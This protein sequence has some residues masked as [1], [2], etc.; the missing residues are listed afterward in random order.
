[1]PDQSCCV[2]SKAK[3]RVTLG[4]VEEGIAE[5][6]GVQD[7]RIVFNNIGHIHENLLTSQ[8]RPDERLYIT[9][10]MIGRPISIFGYWR[11]AVPRHG[12]ISERTNLV[13]AKSFTTRVPRKGLEKGIQL[14]G[15]I[16]ESCQVLT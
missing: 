1:M 13:E 12:N 6:V 7:A 4:E 11:K 8:M 15:G 2:E 10:L 14:F 3:G 9:R 16:S 5:V